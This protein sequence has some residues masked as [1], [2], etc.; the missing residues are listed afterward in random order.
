M[1]IDGHAA[2]GKRLLAIKHRLEGR[3]AIRGLPHATASR[4]DEPDTRIFRIDGEI[5]DAPRGEGRTDLTKL[6]SGEGLFAVLGFFLFRVF[7][8]RGRRGSVSLLRRLGVEK[9]S[10]RK[11]DDEH[12][13]KPL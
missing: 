9:N 7:F 1:R 5:D 8:F 4:S 6:E 13:G 3:S 2:D 10:E 12:A 11:E